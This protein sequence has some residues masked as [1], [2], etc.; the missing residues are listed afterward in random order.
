MLE[1][2][3]NFHSEPVDPIEPV[4]YSMLEEMSKGIEDWAGGPVEM[5]LPL[6]GRSITMTRE[7][8]TG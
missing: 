3:T 8:G 1:V 2:R 6:T 5:R 7:V 4:L